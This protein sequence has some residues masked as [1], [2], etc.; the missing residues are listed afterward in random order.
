MHRAAVIGCG[1]IGSELDDDPLVDGIQSHAGA[2]TQLAQTELVAVCDSDKQKARR[3]A[4]RWN[5]A[6]HYADYHTML[7]EQQPD[8]VSVCTPDET[9]HEVLRATLTA[10][11]VRGVLVEKPLALSVAETEELARLADERGITLAVNYS[12]RYATSHQQLQEFL[13]SGAIGDIQAVGGYYTKGTLHNGTHWFD[14][15]RF[16]VGDIRRV[17]GR[18]VLHEGGNDPTLDA[19]M[20]FDGGAAAHLHACRATAYTVF[21]MDLIGTRGRVQLN[22]SGHVFQTYAVADSQRYSGYRGLV[23]VDGVAG[24]LDNVLLNAVEDLVRAVD[25][26]AP[27]LCSA[28]DGIAALKVAV[29][30]RESARTGA[31]MDITPA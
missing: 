29:A 26:G 15:A 27:P 14:L 7:A 12:R 18:D 1:R 30:A 4:E 10:P 17:W 28:A 22:D 19:F 13:A 11:G 2:Y 8:L 9:H 25:E 31:A 3:C 20:E 16:L 24:G 21:E 6:A 5:V 23:P